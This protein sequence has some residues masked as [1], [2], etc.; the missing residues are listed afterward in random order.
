MLKVWWTPPTKAPEK[1]WEINRLTG[2]KIYKKQKTSP[3]KPWQQKKKK[4]WW[5]PP[6]K[7]TKTWKSKAKPTQRSPKPTQWKPKPPPTRGQHI[8]PPTRWQPKPPPTKWKP[9]PP[10][11]QFKSKPTKSTD[12]TDA[13][14]WSPNI[15]A[16][17]LPND[18]I[19]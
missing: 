19:N 18:V 14:V 10:P 8:P 1:N 12:I 4:V 13:T 3:K 15:I 11:T 6:T 7:A 2:Q 16:S 9:K 17:K 5:T